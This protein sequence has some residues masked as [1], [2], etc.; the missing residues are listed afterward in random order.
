LRKFWE[1]KCRVA[2][3][4][5]NDRPHPKEH[6]RLGWRRGCSSQRCF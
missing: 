4:R 3:L 6:P 1:K 5:V 2:A